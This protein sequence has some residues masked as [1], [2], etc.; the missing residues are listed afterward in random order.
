MVDRLCV[1]QEVLQ[2]GM[3]GCGAQQICAPHHMG[4][5]LRR[6]IHH[7][8]KMISCGTITAGQYNISNIINKMIDTVNVINWCCEI[9]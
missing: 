4:D 9:I 1:A 3:N 8:S 5:V 6:I 7:D 2:Y